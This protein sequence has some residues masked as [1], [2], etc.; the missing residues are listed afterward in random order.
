MGVP[1]E[2]EIVDAARAATDSFFLG[3]IKTKR[4]FRNDMEL[5]RALIRDRDAAL[6][7]TE[8]KQVKS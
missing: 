7:K 8:R 6:A 3:E 5:L 1:S 2:S 4:S